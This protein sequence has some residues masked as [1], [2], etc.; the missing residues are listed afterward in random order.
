MFE[1][2]IFLAVLVFGVT[3]FKNGEL[4]RELDAYLASDFSKQEGWTYRKTVAFKEGL[5]NGY[6][7]KRLS[8]TLHQSEAS[9]RAKLVG[10]K[11]YDQYLERQVDIGEANF[12]ELEKLKRKIGKPG[13]L[14]TK[15]LDSFT[16]E[17]CVEPTWRLVQ[18]LTENWFDPRL[19]FCETFY[20]SLVT[21][22]EDP[23]S[24]HEVVKHVAAFLN[25]ADG[26]VLI[27]FGMKG[28]L[29]GLLDDDMR[30][31]NHYKHRLEE[32]L[33]KCLGDAAQRFVK[34]HMIRWGSED[35]CLVDCGK[36]ESEVRCIHQQYNEAVRL[37]KRENLVYRRANAQ[38]TYCT[39]SKVGLSVGLDST[40]IC[41]TGFTK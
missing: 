25:S 38:S 20:T 24:Q 35:I 26:R 18:S 2:L 37:D 9:V 33:R 27:G 28:K 31:L 8:E 36:S 10:M 21:A 19:E 6:D 40:A 39:L 30:T 17:E 32:T 23:R 34:V 15:P 7:I 16:V 1:I 13:R 11:L 5:A 14:K 29:L 3:L 4:R 22:K 12:E 41:Q